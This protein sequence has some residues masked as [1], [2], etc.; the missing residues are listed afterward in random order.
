MHTPKWA[1]LV[2]AL[3][4]LFLIAPAHQASA[5]K[6]TITINFGHGANCSIRGGICSVVIDLELRTAGGTPGGNADGSLDGNELTV[7]MNEPI[8]EGHL[9]TRGKKQWLVLA[10]DIMVKLAPA[11]AKKVGKP[12]LTVKKGEYPVDLSKNRMGS[13]TLEVKRVR[14]SPTRQSTG[15]K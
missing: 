15:G 10:E 2:L 3:V 7:N 6:I 13:F 11:A 4:G 1:F 5:F 9:V 8:P 14:E 12:S